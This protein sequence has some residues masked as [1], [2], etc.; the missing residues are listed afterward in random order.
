MRTLSV[1]VAGEVEM[2]F[3]ELPNAASPQN[4]Q[5]LAVF[6]LGALGMKELLPWHPLTLVRMNALCHS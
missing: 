2:D 6:W 4:P 3:Q 1:Y 5:S